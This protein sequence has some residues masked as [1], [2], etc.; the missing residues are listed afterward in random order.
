MIVKVF[1]LLVSFNETA[2]FYVVLSLWG[3]VV[4]LVSIVFLFLL[5]GIF[6][7]HRIRRL[8]VQKD[9][10]VLMFVAA[11]LV[12]IFTLVMGAI[13]FVC[14]RSSVGM[15]ISLCL[16]SASMLSLMPVLS[17]VIVWFRYTIDR[18]LQGTAR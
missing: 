10:T 5:F 15:L 7:S 12:C 8:Y 17:E 9:G 18:L 16:L 11:I 3:A 13:L 14:A 1:E 6:T 2:A 4:F